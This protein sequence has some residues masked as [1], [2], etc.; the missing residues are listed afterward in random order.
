M[1]N[2]WLGPKDLK[3]TT[4]KFE[5]ESGGSYR[6]IHTDNKGQSFAFHGVFHEV[7]FPER[8]IQTFEYEGEEKGHVALETIQFDS[9]SDNRTRVIAQSLF[10]SVA[11]RDFMIQSGMEQG[12]QESHQKLDDLLQKELV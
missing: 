5:A 10:Q 9:L 3:M 12:V 7:T 11:D 2:E 4:E 6:Y 8:I 1:I